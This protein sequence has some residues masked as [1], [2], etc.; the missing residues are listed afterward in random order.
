MS[1][2]LFPFGKI[3]RSTQNFLIVIYHFFKFVLET[4]HYTFIAPLLGKKRPSLGETAKQMVI[5]GVDSSPIVFTIAIF[6]GMILAMQTA[7][8]LQKYGILDLV[9]DLVSVSVTRELGPLIT[10]VIIAG[11]IGASYSAEIGTMNVEEEIDALKS[12]ALNPIRFLV[13]PRLI[14]MIIML[15]CLTVL[16][17]IMGIVGGFIISYFNLGLPASQYINHVTNALVLKDIITGL[18]KSIFFGMIVVL[19]GCFQGFTVKNGAEGVGKN[20][21]NSVVASIFLIIVAD[22]FFTALFYFAF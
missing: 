21:T 3:G 4:I 9:G 7:Y 13:S 8:Q 17:N 12:M 5:V 14:A 16:A 2:L 19:V 20:T 15:P 22:S 11:R 1:K 6:I 10:A 18:I